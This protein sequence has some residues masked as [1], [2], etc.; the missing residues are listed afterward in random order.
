[1]N[2]GEC[3]HYRKCAHRLPSPRLNLWSLPDASTLWYSCASC[4]VT[5]LYVLPS[6]RWIWSSSSLEND[7]YGRPGRSGC[8]VYWRGCQ[9]KEWQ[10]FR[11]PLYKSSFIG[12]DYQT[13][14]YLG[15]EVYITTAYSL[16]Y[17]LACSWGLRV[18]SSDI[19]KF[20][21]TISCHGN[22]IEFREYLNLKHV[23]CTHITVLSHWPWIMIK[24]PWEWL[25]IAKHTSCAKPTKRGSPTMFTL[26]IRQ[27]SF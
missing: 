7:A 3:R 4:L 25:Q 2:E 12:N 15:K 27:T 1:M 8:Y 20:Y 21:V 10:L 23:L 19:Q 9:H 6:L 11:F 17:D 22:I 16:I 5:A 24:L 26:A 13:V 14:G 18:V